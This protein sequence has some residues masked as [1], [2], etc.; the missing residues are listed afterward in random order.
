MSISNDRLKSYLN[1][2]LFERWFSDDQETNQ[3]DNKDLRWY[4]LWYLLLLSLS[5][6]CI[7]R[8]FGLV[9]QKT[10]Q[11]QSC[12]QTLFWMTGKHEPM[13]QQSNKRRRANCLTI[14]FGETIAVAQW[15]FI[16]A[17]FIF[18][19]LIVVLNHSCLILRKCLGVPERINFGSTIRD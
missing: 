3:K 11:K 9:V 16:A 19:C 12:F 10:V 15:R 6:L 17:S 5:L 1:A 4:R 13:R 14:F 8:V 18:H 2:L 7:S